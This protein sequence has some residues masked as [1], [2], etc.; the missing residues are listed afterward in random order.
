[1][2]EPCAAC[3]DAAEAMTVLA[4]GSA[5]QPAPC[6]RAD[7]S[8]ALVLLDLVDARSGDRVLVHG[9]VAIALAEA[10]AP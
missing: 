5:L 7:G 4:L 2:S 10:A 6:E 8:V 3:A 9:G 1:M